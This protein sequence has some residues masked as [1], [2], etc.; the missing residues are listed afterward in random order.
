M[1]FVVIE[2]DELDVRA[3]KNASHVVRGASNVANAICQAIENNQLFETSPLVRYIGKKPMTVEQLVTEIYPGLTPEQHTARVKV[4]SDRLFS[5]FQF[6]PSGALRLLAGLVSK[7][8]SSQPAPFFQEEVEQLIR[9]CRALERFKAYCYPTEDSDLSVSDWL[10]CLGHGQFEVG[11]DNDK[12][13][14][15]TE[16]INLEIEI[17]ALLETL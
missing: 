5:Q 16:A 11:D 15:D 8:T 13:G 14:D 7:M 4:I 1:P 17:S 10:T 6:S 9:L 3:F 2:L 12:T